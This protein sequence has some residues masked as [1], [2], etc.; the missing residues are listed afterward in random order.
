M[1]DSYQ[2][3]YD[4]VRSKISGADAGQAIKDAL[5]NIPSDVN[6]HVLSLCQEISAEYT[7]PSVMYKPELS[8]DGDM[9]CASYGNMPEGVQGFGKSPALALQDFDKNWSAKLDSAQERE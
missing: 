1:S 4:A 9:W 7:R 5:I 8:I 6:H 3:I 2:P